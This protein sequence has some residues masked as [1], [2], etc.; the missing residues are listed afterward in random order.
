MEM[1]LRS[2]IWLGP[3]D[4]GTVEEDD[5]EA[6]WGYNGN[7]A[8]SVSGLRLLNETRRV[9]WVRLSLVGIDWAGRVVNIKGTKEGGQRGQKKEDKRLTKKKRKGPIERKGN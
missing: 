5:D 4:D 9:K 6:L 7:D 8:T 1:S 3:S 2:D